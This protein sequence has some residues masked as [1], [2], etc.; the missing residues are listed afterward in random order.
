MSYPTPHTDH[1]A[2]AAP[3]KV[4][5]VNHPDTSLRRPLAPRRVVTEQIVIDPT[6][7]RVRILPAS[8]H[9]CRALVVSMSTAAGQGFVGNDRVTPTTGFPAATVIPVEFTTTDAVY[10]CATAGGVVTV[11]VL[12]EYYDG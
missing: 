11:I 5:V 7:D 3:V 2:M 9:R 12:S 10:A 4:E 8:P 1:D 6:L